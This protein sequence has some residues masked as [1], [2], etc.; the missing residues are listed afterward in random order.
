MRA[1]T[2]EAVDWTTRPLR[3][4]K[5]LLQE[6]LI[7]D[8]DDLENFQVLITEHDSSFVTPRHRH[9][10]DQLRWVLQG[11][12]TAGR[13]KYVNEGEVAFFSDG[14]FYGGQGVE[15]MVVLNIKFG[16]PNG[17]GLMNGAVRQGGYA[18]LQ[19]TGTF[20]DGFYRPAAED[21]AGDLRPRDAYE[22]IWEHLHGRPITYSKPPR[23]RDV[24]IMEPRSFHP[25]VLVP[26]VE[27]RPLGTFSEAGTEIRHVLAEAGAEVSF[28]C[29]DHQV[30]LFLRRGRVTHEGTD[31]AGYAAFHL[32]RGEHA[33]FAV[34]ERVE[35][36]ELRLPDLRHLSAAAR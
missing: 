21:A 19:E 6:L 16:S 9:N 14:T 33:T 22:A 25:R 35:L 27:V 26:G 17:S 5:A 23:Y 2:A 8:D 4:G 3:E 11:R 34:G 32:Q 13:D 28:G 31:Y 18:E 15:D 29:A 20:E 1:S 36:L 10:F 12:W 7:G 30:V 24:L